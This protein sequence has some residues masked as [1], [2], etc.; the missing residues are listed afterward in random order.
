MAA[1]RPDRVGDVAGAGFE[2]ARRR[3]IDGLLERDVRDH[4]AAALP[5]RH[6]LEH[7]RLA[8]QRADAGRAEDLV[9]GED[10]EVAVERLH[11]DAHVRDGLRAIDQHA[12]APWR[13]AISTISRAG[14]MVPSAFETCVKETMRVRGLSSFSYSSR[15]IWPCVIDR[16]DAKCA[17]FSEASCC[18]GTMLAWCS[19]QVM[20]ISSPAFDVAPAPALGDQVDGLGRAAREDDLSCA[21]ARSGSAATRSRAPS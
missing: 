9:A 1:P 15:M 17:P 16:R 3:L 13:C 14:V 6:V 18:Q 8:E 7:L 5:G 12:S 20:T 11:V 4:V 10:V 2:A 21:K 19:S